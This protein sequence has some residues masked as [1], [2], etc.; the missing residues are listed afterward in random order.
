MLGQIEERIAKRRRGVKRQLSRGEVKDV[1]G[2][3]GLER[4]LRSLK[5]DLDDVN[6]IIS[7][8]NKQCVIQLSETNC[9]EYTK[10]FGDE[11]YIDEQLTLKASLN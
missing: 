7:K 2:I 4:D 9:G 6:D 8:V 3:P 10:T 5:K 11:Y 1:K